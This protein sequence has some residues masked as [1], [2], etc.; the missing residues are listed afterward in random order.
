[1]V[2]Q[3]PREFRGSLVQT[4]RGRWKGST[5]SDCRDAC[6]VSALPMYFAAVDSTIASNKPATIYFELK[7]LSTKQRLRGDECSLAVGF[8]AIPYPTWRMP[9]WERGSLAVHS[10]DGRRYVSDN[11][12]GKDFAAPFKEGE[13]VGIGIRFFG[14]YASQSSTSSSVKG[15]LNGEAFFTRNGRPDGSWNIH[16]EVDAE[17][18]SDT[19]GLNGTCDLYACVGAYGAISFEVIFDPRQWQYKP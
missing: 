6:L 7:L 18:S 10:D 17:F 14:P 19:Q 2:L 9:G 3:K 4:Q 8:C 5:S 16:E 1:M 11:E 15:A 13:V 12:G